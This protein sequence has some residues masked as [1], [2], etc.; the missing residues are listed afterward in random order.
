M[1]PE[2][3]STKPAVVKPGDP[4]RINGAFFE[5]GS[6]VFL[7]TLGT[8][9]TYISTTEIE[10]TV[11]T[12]TSIGVQN[13]TVENS[14]GVSAV[15]SQIV[16]L[17]SAENFTDCPIKVSE[18]GHQELY[19]RLLPRGLLWIVKPNGVLDRL[20]GGFAAEMFRLHSRLCDL[21]RERSPLTSTELLEEWAE[22]VGYPS[23]CSG[24]VVAADINERRSWIYRRLINRGGQT[25][26]YFVEIAKLF[27]YVVNI[28]EFSGNPFFFGSGRMGDRFDNSASY[29]WT[30][31]IVNLSPEFFLFGV[32]RFGDR[33]VEYADL[34]ALRCIFE[35]LKP[36]H[37][38]LSFDFLPPITEILDENGAPDDF[39]DENGAVL[40]NQITEN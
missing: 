7:G 1:I 21:L 3:F 34:F 23:E 8:L 5:P 16:G 28:R 26:A 20:F 22:T 6:T 39:I 13:L 32:N 40:T 10:I 4:L 33:F 38:V 12:E 24:G 19:R 9:A 11:A 25:P 17:I 14:S 36:A 29:F 2:I 18:S 15:F 30:V 27:G 37:T 35:Q 31:E